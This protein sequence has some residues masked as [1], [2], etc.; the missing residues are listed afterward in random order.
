MF[1]NIQSQPSSKPVLPK[2]VLQKRVLFIGIPDMAYVC[3]DGLTISEVNIIG[4]LGPKKDHPTYS[5]FKQFVQIKNLNYIE[6]D[7][8]DDEIFIEKIRDLNADIAVVCSFNYKV[9]K[10]LLDSVKGGFIN[11]HP[12]LLPKYRGSNP[13]SSVIINNER[14][15][16]VTLH[17]MDEGFDTGDIIFQNSLPLSPSET[18]GTLFNRTNILAFHMIMEALKT[19]EE[20][21]LPRHKQPEGVFETGVKFKDEDL[22]IDY[23]KPAREIESFIRSLNPFILAKTKF[24]GTYVKI[25]TA[26]SI[27]DASGIDLTEK[28]P[29]GTIVKIENEKFYISTGKGLIV[30]TSMQFGSFFSGTSKEFI[31]ILNPKIGEQFS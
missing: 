12:S 18:M 8:L 21:E 22:F 1:K 27:D 29:L 4:V 5:D 16:G 14:E 2:R 30:P 17:F 3:L 15:T 6:Y 19:Y 13:Y 9:P 11:V 28:H 10:V 24:R 7:E 20:G 26:D 25:F 31:K 23:K